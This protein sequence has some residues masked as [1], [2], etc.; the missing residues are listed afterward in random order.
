MNMESSY[1]DKQQLP[2]AARKGGGQ[3]HRE[4]NQTVHNIRQNRRVPGILWR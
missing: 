1:D 4:K 2:W 3:V